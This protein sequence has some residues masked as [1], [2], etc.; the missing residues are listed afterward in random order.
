MDLQMIANK[1]SCPWITRNE[2][3]SCVPSLPISHQL[4]KIHLLEKN[5][6]VQLGSDTMLR[7][8]LGDALWLVAPITL[9]KSFVEHIYSTMRPK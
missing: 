6:G 9:Q 8:R 5:I 3:M 2:S 7:L 4:V 1:T